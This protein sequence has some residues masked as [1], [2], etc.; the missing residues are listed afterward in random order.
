MAKNSEWGA[1]A[2]L[3]QSKYGKYGN[4]KYTGVEKEVMINDCSNYITGV[5]A[6]SQNTSGSSSTCTTNTY[7]TGKGQAAST[8]GN[9]TGIYDMSGGSCEYVMANYNKTSGNSGVNF[10]TLNEKYYDLYT[11][12]DLE[13]SCNG[14]ICYGHALSE[15]KEWYSDNLFFVGSWFDRG[16]RY[17]SGNSSTGIF[18]NTSNGGGASTAVTF[19]IVISKS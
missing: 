11:S 5:G 6:D 9:I 8:T 18:N 19:R 15:T 14:E 3:S 17:L 16:G 4:P 13:T 12:L 7:E 10:S 1:V 2:Y